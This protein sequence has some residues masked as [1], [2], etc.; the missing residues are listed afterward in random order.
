[1]APVPCRTCSRP[2]LTSVSGRCRV[3]GTKAGFFRQR[4]AA[5]K[6]QSAITRRGADRIL[7]RLEGDGLG[8][9]AASPAGPT[10]SWQDAE[11][12]ARDWMRR[13][14]CRDAS[15]TGNGTDGGVDVRS[16]VAVAQ[17][18]FWLTKP[19]G[20]SEVQR[21]YGI[22]A[23]E[24]R[25]ALLFSVLG[26]TPAA[27]AWADKHGIGLLSLGPVRPLNRHANRS[28]ARRV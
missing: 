26:F 1:M 9:I 5:L 16:K 23:A 21:L 19:V 18:K 2:L 6:G 17:V 3:C 12:E 28:L 14:G 22:A 27:V 8:A 20:L 4:H 24:G 25:R 13:N 15:L 7:R 11:C 10:P